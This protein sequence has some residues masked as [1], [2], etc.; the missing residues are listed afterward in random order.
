MT[1]MFHKTSFPKF[2]SA[3]LGHSRRTAFDALVISGK[4]VRLQLAIL[5]IQLTQRVA[6]C[7]TARAFATCLE[8]LLIYKAHLAGVRRSEAFFATR[9][10]LKLELGGGLQ[11]KPG[12]INLD[13]RTED[14][15]TL[16]LRR[17]L[18]FPHESVSEIYTEHLLEHLVY[19][20][21]LKR[22]LS[23]CYRV[24]RVGGTLTAGVPDAGRA[25]KAYATGA[26][27]FYCDKYWPNVR[28]VSVNCPMDELN[29]LIYMGGSHHHMFDEENLRLR[30]EEASFVEIRK[31]EAKSTRGSVGR[32]HQT[33]YV[34]AKKGT[35][36]TRPAADDIRMRH[37]EQMIDQVASHTE[38]ALVVARLEDEERHAILRLAILI[39]GEWGNTL[40]VG[41]QALPILKILDIF[42]TPRGVQA[43]CVV[44]SSCNQ[45]ILVQELKARIKFT[46]YPP[47]PFP[48]RHFRRVVTIMTRD[49]LT[50]N[51][52]V[53]EDLERVLTTGKHGRI[54]VVVPMGVDLEIPSVLNCFH[55]ESLPAKAGT[56]LILKRSTA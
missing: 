25:F 44:K 18:P 6:P 27:A 5:A 20:T 47:F 56:L 34:E 11:S 21:E 16:D 13:L 23:E 42:K 7:G 50:V 10:P 49:D 9:T 53:L 40:V 33:I 17:P 41:Q 15:L 1:S 26:G 54:Y 24:L 29:W 12:W 51:N 46:D 22:L 28:P 8:E 2:N 48:D 55:K 38:I 39:A 45:S 3:I 36:D 4:S 32:Q 35:P 37:M 52:R 31:K 14:G 19:P 43:L 30:L